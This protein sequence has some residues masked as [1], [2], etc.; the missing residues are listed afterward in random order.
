MITLNPEAVLLVP[1]VLSVA[2]LV[3][4]LRGLWRDERRHATQD[5]M[6]QGRTSRYRL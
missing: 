1:A 2:F 6:S 4:A 3:W 5:N